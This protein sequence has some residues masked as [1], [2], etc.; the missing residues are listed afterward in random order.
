MTLHAQYSPSKLARILNCPGSAALTSSFSPASSAAQVGTEKHKAVA[1]YLFREQL[2]D[3]S[4]LLSEEHEDV[5]EAIQYAHILQASA[6][7]PC[8]ITLIE[9]QINH[10]AGGLHDTE[11]T[12]DFAVLSLANKTA[13][14][15]D[16]KFGYN[17]VNAPNN[18]Q[19]L[20]YA[21]GVH[22][23]LYP[24]DQ[25]NIKLHIFQP[26]ISHISTADIDIT[27]IT[28]WVTR[29]QTILKQ[30]QTDSPTYNPS[31]S[32]C[33]WCPGAATCEAFKQYAAQAAQ[34]AFRLHKEVDTAK[35]EKI[36]QIL[37]KEAEIKSYF[38]VLK[39]YVY[40][41]LKQGKEFP[42]FKLVQQRGRRKW[43]DEL[44]TLSFLVAK[45]L[46]PDEIYN[47]KMRSPSQIEKMVKQLKTDEIF[48]SLYEVPLGKVI[49]APESDKRPAYEPFKAFKPVK[50]VS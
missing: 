1:R 13:H 25:F 6:S 37:D 7:D 3:K 19:L 10:R 46:E 4:P 32:T 47:A 17:Q 27:D 23:S 30:I 24:L 22:L 16:W 41:T 49:V 2:Y 8:Y 5:Q 26:A 9:Q 21:A 31:A 45:G 28:S 35:H 34:E 14:I 44:E 40:N 18:D 48:R 42:G 15:V 12:L 33:R 20:A 50:E 39:D 11:G 43:I 29:A 38:A 36:K